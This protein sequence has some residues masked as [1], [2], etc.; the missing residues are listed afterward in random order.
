MG[1]A[2]SGVKEAATQATRSGFEAIKERTK[3]AADAAAQ[4]VADA[5]LG[6][7]TTRM[8]RNMADAL[9]EA[10]E[11]VVSAAFDPSRTPNS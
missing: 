9:R 11:H 1:P 10:G 6:A 5:D 7:Q 2:S 3:S 4:S 8:T